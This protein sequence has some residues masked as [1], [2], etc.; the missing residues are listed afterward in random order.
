LRWISATRNFRAINRRRER[1]K[2]A[3]MSSSAAAQA[4]ARAGKSRPGAR[5]VSE[6][7]PFRLLPRLPVVIV[8]PRPHW[9]HL[10]FVRRGSLLPRI[11]PQQ[12]F[13]L[14]L[15][16]AVVVAHGSSSTSRSR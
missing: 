9:I 11:L 3:A 2:G 6:F 8:R 13:V 7:T 12:I 10:L 14:L 1:R 5:K 16:C 4:P 15:S